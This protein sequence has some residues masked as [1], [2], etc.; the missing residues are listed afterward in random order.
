MKQ[1]INRAR[2]EAN[3][4][5]RVQ[6][7]DGRV[8]VKTADGRVITR[9]RSASTDPYHVPPELIPDGWVYQWNRHSVYNQEDTSEQIAMAENGWTPVPAGRHKGQY[10]PASYPDEKPI[11][12]D[13]LMLCERPIELEMEARA[14]EKAKADALVRGSKEQFG[15]KTTENSGFSTNTPNAR[16]AT[17]IRQQVEKLPADI[18]PPRHEVVIDE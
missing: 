12:R 2:T 8:A 10:M 15:M 13:G 9:K 7:I 14:E 17:F 1:P 5:A 18:A 11:L 3:S 4:D 16:N 6:M